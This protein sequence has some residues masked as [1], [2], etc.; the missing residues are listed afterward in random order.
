MLYWVVF[1]TLDVETD[2]DALHFLLKSTKLL[3][4]HAECL[5]P[6]DPKHEAYCKQVLRNLLIPK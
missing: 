5:T 2:A 1:Q 6:S 3:C 4:L